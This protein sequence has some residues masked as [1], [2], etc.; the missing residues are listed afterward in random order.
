MVTG[1]FLQGRCLGRRVSKLLRGCLA[2]SAA[3][4]RVVVFAESAVEGKQAVLYVREQ[5]PDVSIHLFTIREPPPETIG[6]CER[7]VAARGSA[8]LLL[9]ALRS[10][11]TSWAALTI[12]IWNGTRTHPLLKLAPFVVPRFRVLIMNEHGDFFS[13]TPALI[14]LHCFRRG[15]D[16]IHSFGHRTADWICGTRVFLIALLA[17]LRTEIGFRFRVSEGWARHL[18]R[19]AIFQLRLASGWGRRMF[20]DPA[21]SALHI[22]RGATYFCIADLAHRSPRFAAIV[23]PYLH[24]RQTLPVAFQRE[25]AQGIAVFEYG[26]LHVD[27]DELERLAGNSTA[28]WI[29][30]VRAGADDSS[31][32]WL[33]LFEDERTFA[34]AKQCGYRSTKTL[35]TRGPI[36]RLQGGEACRVLAPVSDAILVDRAKLVALGVPRACYPETA[37]LM[38]FWKAAAAGFRCYS[39]SSLGDRELAML[40]DWPVHESEFVTRVFS[41]PACLR[42]GPQNPDLCR[43][44]VSFRIGAGRPFRAKPRVLIVAPYLPYP[45]S[46]GGAVRVYNLCRVLS[47]RVDFL[48]AAFRE[49]NDVIDYARL[50]D[51]FRKVWVVDKETPEKAFSR[52]PQQV[53]EYQ[54]RPMK[55]LVAEICREERPDLLQIEYTQLA[56]L[57]RAAPGVPA[58][59]AEHDVTFALYEQV[60]RLQQTRAARQDYRR[61]LRFERRWLRMYD[62]IWTVS[63]QDCRIAVSAGSRVDRT[64]VVP[65][66]VDTD[67]FVPEEQPTS[68]PEIL[69]VG[70]FRHFPNVAGFEHLYQDVMPRVWSHH[71]NARL[72][73][74]AGSEPEKYWKRFAGNGTSANLDTRIRVHGFIADLR[75]FYRRA[76]VV[77]APLQVSAGTNI[78]VLEALA[79]GKALVTT[80]IGCHGLDLADGHDALIR[81]DWDSFARAVNELLSE[82]HLVRRLGVNG[83]RTAEGRFNWRRI[84]DEAFA[85]YGMVTA[86]A[87]QDQSLSGS[88]CVRIRPHSAA[89][90]GMP[91]V[92]DRRP[93]ST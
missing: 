66:G 26:D 17:R 91:I 77:V 39:V 35:V 88:S 31:D 57:R 82:D 78:K 72:S 16:R 64:F 25:P 71:R 92:A 48:L 7:V 38:L 86:L 70:A 65:N 29:L 50:H 34:V 74:V 2:V 79:C 41:E 18:L 85:S 67:W 83:R 20:R 45:P 23:F 46:H 10:F 47:D 3:Q 32:Q 33:P 9:Q 13:G 21:V 68:A 69:Y 30:L 37:W 36:R 93:H 53:T 60:A 43:G 44:T 81:N 27:W 40:P 80:S 59:L 75:P 24:G 76:R 55:A 8:E 6:L 12:S 51:V 28:R 19:E 14:W 15:R 5:L 11:W 87:G 84:A 42:L 58:I 54:S 61:W 1:I 90:G 52:D 56:P 62:A 89:D 4:Q 63:K 49:R 22:L 73:V